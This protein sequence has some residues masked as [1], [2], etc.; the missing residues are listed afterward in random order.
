MGILRVTKTEVKE[1]YEEVVALKKDAVISISRLSA[2]SENYERSQADIALSLQTSQNS[3]KQAIASA[4]ECERFEC[5]IKDLHSSAKESYAS[6]KGFSESIDAITKRISSAEERMNKLS[7]HSEEL[8]KRVESLL[9]G[10]TS[11]GLASAFKDRKDSFHKPARNWSIVF[12]GSILSLLVVAYVNPV[13]LTVEHITEENFIKYMLMR[14]PF[15]VPIVWLAIYSSHRHSQALRL[16]EEYAHKEAISKSF[17]G[18]KSQLLE[19]ESDSNSS[20]AEHLVNRTLEALA[21]HPGRVYDAKHE[22]ISPL[23]VVKQW[24]SIKKDRSSEEK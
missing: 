15:I 4:I 13:T 6:V 7:L 11:A 17:E 8:S 12:I 24:F 20:A 9:P 14:L 10:A 18:Y 5:E 2:A 3:E 16:E 22:D 23:S 1:L 21:R 19:I